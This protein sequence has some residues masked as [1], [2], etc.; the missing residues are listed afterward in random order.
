MANSSPATTR[1]SFSAALRQATWDA[2]G[3][4]E[5]APWLTALV[6]GE[7]DLRGYAELVAQ[8]HFAYAALEAAVEAMRDDPAAGPFVD[9]RL[10]RGPALVADLEALLGPGWRDEVAPSPATAA[11]V[12][13]LEAVCSTWPGGF[14]AHH[15]VRYLGDL[16]GGQ[17]L[18]KRIEDV[19]DIGPSSGTAFYDFARI[20]DLGAYKDDYRAKLDEV[21]W[22][23]DERAR[24]IDEVLVG[25][26][27]NTAV[28]QELGR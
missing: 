17:M 21:P 23:D 9:D 14:V 11:Y 28:L 24:V 7:V 8:H 1:P 20:D 6:A 10:T 2:H 13:R 19:Y 27:H 18:R 25:Y 22:D 15:Y 26:R 12:A 3:D 4:A 5:Q 16:S